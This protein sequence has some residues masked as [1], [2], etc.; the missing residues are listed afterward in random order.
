M[1]DRQEVRLNFRGAPL[2]ALGWIL[3]SAL[4]GLLFGVPLAWVNSAIARWVCRKTEFSDGSTAEFRGSG[5]E[6]AVWHVLLFLAMLGQQWAISRTDPGD[7]GSLLAIFGL[8]YVFMIGIA[9]M[10]LKWFVFNLRVTPGPQLTFTGSLGGLLG[11]YVAILLSCVTIVGWAWVVVA[12][13]QW[14]TRNTKGEGIA[15]EFRATGL[16]FL[17]RALVTGLGCAL[18]VTIPFLFVWF[19]RWLIG[20]FVLIRGVETEWGGFIEEQRTPQKPSWPAVPPLHR[21]ID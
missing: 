16:E 2:Q 7:Y 13:Y 18:I 8:T 20:Q 15:F 5:G 10:L 21:H 1:P 17:W 19:T 6:V 14:I 11:W 4:G 12:M 3:A 9:L